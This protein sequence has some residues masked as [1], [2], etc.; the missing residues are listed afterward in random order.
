PDDPC[1]QSCG[2]APG[3]GCPDVNDDPECQK[4]AY[5][6][7]TED[8]PNLRCWDQKR[9]YGVDW[10]YPVDRYLKG[11]TSSQ[12][13]NRAGQL[14]PNPLLAARAP[15]QIVVTG[16]VGVPWQ[17]LA[18]P[19]T[20][21]GSAPLALQSS[22]ALQWAW[23]VPTGKTPPTDPLMRESVDPRT[24]TQPSTGQ[25]L[26]PPTA[27][28][29]ANGSNGHEWSPEHDDLQYACIM[30]LKE[31]R[32][33][34]SATGGCDCKSAWEPGYSKNSPLCQVPGTGEYTGYQRFA[35][36]YP[37]TRHLQLLH[38]LGDRGVVGSVCA[39]TIEGSV[40][41]VGYGYNPA[42]TRTLQRLELLLK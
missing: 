36:A 29:G 17:D 35:K 24:G 21:A 39:K 12:I 7:T 2:E 6:Q 25:A 41:D 10:L 16:I 19:E 15:G 40:R 5:D 28:P 14:V 42:F 18:T 34:Q 27:G 13:E 20:L 38:G 23:L 11:L 33:C 3:P 30:P 4:G 31:P 26:A 8:T 9:R 1:C 37:G 22:S 32:N